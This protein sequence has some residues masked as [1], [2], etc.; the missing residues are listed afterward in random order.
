M[1]DQ[2]DMQLTPVQKMARLTDNPIV[3]AQFQK[4][5][6]KHSDLFVSSIL[7][8]YRS[9]Q[10]LQECDP[11]EV[12]AVALSAATLK[13]PINKSLGF[14]WIVPYKENK[15][16]GNKWESKMVP[17]F[18]IGYKGW[19][20][21]A[22][23]TGLYR[24][25]NADIV[26]E[27]ELVS[28]DKLTGEIDLSGKRKSDVIIGYFAHME[29]ATGFKKTVYGSTAEVVAHAEKYS[30]SYGSNKSP[31]TT[32]PDKMAIKTMLL[33]LLGTYGVVSIEQ[34]GA[35]SKALE[36]DEQTPERH[37]AEQISEAGHEII[38]IPAG[39]EEEQEA[40]ASR[41]CP[42]HEDGSSMFDSFCNQQ[43]EKR[44]G[45]PAWEDDTPAS[46]PKPEAK[47]QAVGCVQKMF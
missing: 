31:W 46:A 39:K 12:V 20:Q 5:L 27:G 11:S 14:A 28:Q 43:C 45:C 2:K 15:K 36:A 41:K 8:L 21:L 37:L 47:N 29:T 1:A 3:R 13:L 9:N 6:N 40:E 38:V 10:A 7:D 35:I 34:S 22:I 4:A 24:Y 42:R 23:R 32:E 26:Y 25:L 17:T 19:I 44:A 33:Q 18:Q 16:V 30:K